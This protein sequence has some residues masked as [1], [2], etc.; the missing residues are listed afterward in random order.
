MNRTQRHR[1]GYANTSMMDIAV[2][3][4]DLC[5]LSECEL[6]ASLVSSSELGARRPTSAL[7]A[8]GEK[9]ACI[10]VDA[11]DAKEETP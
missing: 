1:M 9:K 3:L 4:C 11:K 5:A 10:S 6:T 8:T 2:P 7:G